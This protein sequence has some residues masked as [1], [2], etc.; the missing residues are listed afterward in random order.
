MGPAGCPRRLPAGS[1]LP[2]IDG[3]FVDTRNVALRSECRESVAEEMTTTRE[4]VYAA[5]VTWT[6]NNGRGTAAYDAYARDYDIACTGKRPIRGSA[7]PGYLGDGSRHNP[8][9]LLVAALSACHM[10]W[11]LHLCAANRVVVTGYED[12]AEGTMETHGDGSGEFREV[13][14]RPRVT[15]AADS[16]TETAMRL[17]RQAHAMCFIA[18]SVNFP[19]HHVP[20]IVPA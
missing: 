13:T 14:L 9:D 2:G 5:T 7:D 11:Y 20:E 18:R 17:H 4:H 19:V 3:R 15:I 16:D 1:C 6:G 12:A 8:E 10:L